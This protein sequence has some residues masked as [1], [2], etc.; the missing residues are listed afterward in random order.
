MGAGG[1]SKGRDGGAALDVSAVGEAEL[2][3]ELARRHRALPVGGRLRL[4]LSAVDLSAEVARLLLRGA[5]FERL[6]LVPEARGLVVTATRARTLPDWI[7]PGRRVL[8]CGLNPS[9]YSA[10]AGIPF[11]RPGNRFWPALCAAGLSDRER[12]VEHAYQRGAGFTDL[13][14]RATPASADLAPREYERGVRRLEALVKVF[15][16]Q[17]V[18]FV[19]LEGWRRAIDRNAVPGWVGG[20]FAGAAAYLM[21]STSGRNA[22]TSLAELTAHLRRAASLEAGDR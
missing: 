16:P 12:D 19:G 14:K 15:L 8:F 1:E 3:C 5:G 20:G 9:L 18:C 13:V 4:V 6:R 17:V 22:R 7:G 2:A 21:P 10:D 11:A